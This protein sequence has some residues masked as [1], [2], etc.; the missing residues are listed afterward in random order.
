MFRKIIFFAFI[1]VVAGVSITC[2]KTYEDG[3]LVSFCSKFSRITGKWRLVSMEGVERLNPEVEQYMELTKEEISEG[4]YRAEFTNFQE[5]DCELPDTIRQELFT[6]SGTWS[7]NS[8]YFS[9][10]DYYEDLDENEGLDIKIYSIDHLTVRWK[11][12][13]LTN[14]ELDVYFMGC[15]ESPCYGTSKTLCFEKV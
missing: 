9:G 3:P 5:T 6:S 1:A 11:I 13:K 14:K 15:W 10:C 8:T 12:L 7:F 4:V 2:S